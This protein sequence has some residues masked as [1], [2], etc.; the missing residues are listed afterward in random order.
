MSSW[1]ATATGEGKD[2]CYPAR[3]HATLDLLDRHLA[4]MKD[5]LTPKPLVG[6]APPKQVVR[7]WH[8]CNAVVHLLLMRMNR[9]G[10]SGK[11]GYTV[12][13][14]GTANV[15]QMNVYCHLLLVLSLHYSWQS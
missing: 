15:N 5:Q 2:D 11:S 6:R 10:C 7:A 13:S 1:R 3:V 9:Q 4:T 12:H 8:L 14:L